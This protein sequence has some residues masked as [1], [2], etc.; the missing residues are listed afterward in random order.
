MGPDFCHVTGLFATLFRAYLPSPASRNTTH[1][2]AAPF[3]ADRLPATMGTGKRTHRPFIDPLISCDEAG[4]E[5]ASDV[6]A[7]CGFAATIG[8]GTV[9]CRKSL[10]CRASLNMY[11][12][13]GKMNKRRTWMSDTWSQC[14]VYPYNLLWSLQRT[15][16]ACGHWTLPMSVCKHRESGNTYL[17]FMFPSCVPGNANT[18]QHEGPR[19]ISFKRFKP[20][21][22][23]LRLF[24]SATYDLPR[25]TWHVGSHVVFSF[26]ISLSILGYGTHQLKVLPTLRACQA[27]LLWEPNPWEVAPQAAVPQLLSARVGSSAVGT[28]VGFCPDANDG[29]LS[30]GRNGYWAIGR[31]QA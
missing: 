7:M 16:P 31:F 18:F 26:T 15:Y 11:M 21:K 10:F 5:N 25:F 17:H 4:S 23:T 27:F 6:Y 3:E 20:D 14:F 9:W 29:A 13:L 28:M 30:H 1:L 19:K 24:P 22:P 2:P 12:P 8:N